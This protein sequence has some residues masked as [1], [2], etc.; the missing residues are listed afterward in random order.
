MLEFLAAFSVEQILLYTV[1]LVLA[2]KW[3]IEIIKWAKGLYNEKFNAD[4]AKLNDKE[5]AK[6]QHEETLRKHEEYAVSLEKKIDKLT[7]VFNERIGK[8]ESQLELLTESDMHDIK[9][10]IVDK[11]HHY[12]KTGW[13]DDFTMDTIEKRYSDYVKENGNSYVKGLVNELR[14]LPHFP[15]D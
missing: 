7:E 3:L 9:G 2:I 14:A 8:I 10:W 5:K 13:I 11:H 1:M 15:V 4:Y 6:E 12:V